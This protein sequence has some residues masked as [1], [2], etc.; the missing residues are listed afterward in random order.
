MLSHHTEQNKN[1]STR[2]ILINNFATMTKQSDDIDDR[3][4]E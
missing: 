2:N 1:T 3:E 4:D